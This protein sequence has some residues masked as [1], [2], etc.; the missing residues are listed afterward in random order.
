MWKPTNKHPQSLGLAHLGRNRQMAVVRLVHFPER[1]GVYWTLMVLRIVSIYAIA[2]KHGNENWNQK[3]T[4]Q[5]KLQ[6]DQVNAEQ[7]SGFLQHQKK[8][9]QIH[10]SA[11]GT[12]WQ[13]RQRTGVNVQVTNCTSH[14][15][16]NVEIV[17]GTAA[18]RRGFS[19]DVSTEELS[20]SPKPSPRVT[21]VRLHVTRTKQ[22][23]A[24]PMLH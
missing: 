21:W 6:T 1:Q 14:N 2:T 24:R 9:R 13:H 4:H 23:E 7:R 22:G 20:S 16:E 11:P 15:K 5:G 3:M 8:V 17:E 19:G 10:K 18:L 12:S